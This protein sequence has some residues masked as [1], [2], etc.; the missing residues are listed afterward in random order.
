MTRWIWTVGILLAACPVVAGLPDS[1]RDPKP[2]TLKTDQLISRLAWAPAGRTIAAVSVGFDPKEKRVQSTLQFWDAEKRELQRSVN[3]ESKTEIRSIAYSPDGKCLALASI[4]RAGKTV[5]EVRVIDPNTGAT[6]QTIPLRGTVRSVAYSPDGKTLAIGGQQ[7]PKASNG[8]FIRTVQLW[9][10]EK[11]QTVREFSQNLRI[12]DLTKSGQLDGLRDLQFSPDGSLLAAADVDFRV[13][14]IDVQSGSV[15]QKL[16]GHTEVV[17]GLAFSPDGKVLATAGFDRTARIWDVRT[18]KEIRTLEG[19]NGPVFTI[20]FSPDGNLL[21]TGGMS[22][23]DG[24][25]SGELI[26]WD[27]HSWQ[28][29][30][31]LPSAKGSFE[32]PAFSPDTKTLAIG[33]GMDPGAGAIQFW[34]LGD[35]LQ[36]RR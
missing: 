11:E 30:R 35:L 36:E 20:S 14:L 33:L 21:V 22:L 28:P 12:D 15:Q 24:R 13:H 25:R 32:T 26:L 17:L 7:F 19:N 16:A 6:T 8:P 29:R 31:V 4:R 9:D 5:Y 23:A 2:I 34:N 1:E 27:A 10:V 18:G 3:L